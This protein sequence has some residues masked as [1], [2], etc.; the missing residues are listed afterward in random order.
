M[1]HHTSS[2]VTP[3]LRATVLAFAWLLAVSCDD[4]GGGGGKSKDIGE[5]RAGVVLAMGDSITN[6]AVSAVLAMV[7]TSAMLPNA[8]TAT[9]RGHPTPPGWPA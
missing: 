7:L 2:R 6:G 9:R 4:S 3:L 1:P 8:S 5:N